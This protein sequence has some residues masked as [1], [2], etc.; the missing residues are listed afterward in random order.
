MRSAIALGLALLLGAC[1]M[2]SIL[3]KGQTDGARK[4]T[5][6]RGT[7]F[8]DP[9]MVGPV[10]A[11]GI[12]TN[13]GFLY[14]VPDYEPLLMS[15]VFSNIAYGVGWLQ[16][17]SHQAEI[18]GDLDKAEHLNFRAGLLYARA[19][20]LAKRLLRLRDSGFDAAVA[21]GV[22]SFKQWVDQNFYEERD[23]EP[24]L[25]AAL[26]YAVA[27]IE[28][29]EG[30]AA[31][32]DLPLARYMLERSVE[33]DE[34]LEGGQ[35]LSVIGVMECTMPEML[36]GKPKLGLA[37]LKRAAALTNRTNH[38]VLVS[39]AERCAV[40]LQDRK[41]FTSLLMEVIEA[42]DVEEYRLPNKLARHKAERLLQQID[43]LF[44]D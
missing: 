35:A 11:N 18:D 1:N 17:E 29:E 12:V 42:G 38:G 32:V 13:E 40:A 34:D 9:E 14:Y 30:L 41:M 25:I 21:N 33:L 43:E 19:L 26:A 27:M 5:E 22:D 3:V 37:L 8:A 28:S 7:H 31:A 2:T 20:Y 6:E 16:A 39:M 4:F 10:I 24:L 15:A 44:Y 36:G 23:A